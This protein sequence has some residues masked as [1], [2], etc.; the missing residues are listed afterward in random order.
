M[1]GYI[2]QFFYLLDAPAKKGIP[3]LILAFIFSSILDV[4][5]VGLIGIFLGLLTNPHFFFEKFPTIAFLLHGISEKKLIIFSG[6]LI[7]FAFATKAIITLTIQTKIIF[8]CQ[9]LAVRLKTRMMMAYQYAPYIYH[10]EKNS[11]YLISK[12]QDNVN[13]FIG[14]ILL[15][16]LNLIS[17]GLITAAILLFL[18]F[19]HPFLTIFLLGMFFLVGFSFDLFVKRKLSTMGKIVALSNGEMIKSIH[20]G[21]NGVTEIRVLGR[22][23]Y[24]LQCLNKVSYQYAHA[25]GVIVALQ[26]IPRYLIENMM[27]IFIIGLSMGGIIAGFGMSSVIAMVGMFAAAGARLLPTVTQIMSTINQ[28]RG[29]SYHMQLVYE[30]LNRLDTMAL[31]IAKLK[32]LSQNATKLPFSAI[33]LKHIAYQYPN[34][35]HYALQDIDITLSKGQSIG[36]IGPSGAGKSTLVNVILGFLEPQKGEL[37][38]D[39]QS[40]LHLRAWLNNFA[41]IPQSIFLLDDTLRRNIAL[42]IVDEEIDE[43]QIW[44]AIK[45]AQ[46]VEVVHQMPNGLDTFIGENGIRLSGGQRQRVALARAFYHERDII[47]MDEATS[48]LDNETEKEVINTIKRLKGDKTLIVIAHRLSTVEHCDVLYRLEKGC[49]T[50]IGSFQEVVGEAIS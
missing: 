45:L 44:N 49:I 19:L 10:L 28:M 14:N 47:I 6:L 41:Y 42:G 29:S 40:I 31:D 30:E 39:G 11:A 20:H 8:F 26:Q 22:E 43:I 15:A 18:A 37:C 4:I 38:V 13:S 46:L 21:L 27:A 5:G 34:T 25:A 48:S 24:F 16:V 17:N 2:K 9:S 33:Q 35:T 36:L 12:I 50:A 7:V 1:K 32:S 23:D 3:L